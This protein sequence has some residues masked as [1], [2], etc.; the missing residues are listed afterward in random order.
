MKNSSSLKRT[1]T[2]SWDLVCDLPLFKAVSPE[3]KS[4]YLCNPLYLLPLWAAAGAAIAGL[5]GRFLAWLLPVNGAALVF[6][7]VLLVVSEMRTT[8]RGMALSVSFLEKFIYGKKFAESRM[9]RQSDLRDI[10]GLVPLLLAAAFA[11]CRFFALYWAAKSGNW[12]VIGAAWLIATGAEGFLAGEPAAVNMPGYCSSAKTE[13][14]VMTVGFFLLF[15]LIYLPLATL[16]AV[17]VSA[18]VVLVLMNMFLRSDGRIE[19]ND[20]TMTGYMLELIVLFIY[21]ILIG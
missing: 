12:G 9:L 20:M 6:A 19:S 11:G 14:I 15:N 1:L 17:G 10:T 4:G 16:I 8:F 5:S 7:L 21:A 13:Y 2:D 18:A 3:G